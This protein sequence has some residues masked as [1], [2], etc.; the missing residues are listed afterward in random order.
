[1]ETRPPVDLQ[2]VSLITAFLRERF[3]GYEIHTT[4]DTDRSAQFF[5]LALA[6]ATA[7]R[8]YLAKEFLDDNPT[9]GL[10]ALLDDWQLDARIRAAGARE[11][12]V[13]NRGVSIPRMSD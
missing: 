11:V 9:P 5:H 7:H 10:G 3:P 8:V 4:Y 1:M 2:K 13:T 12:L 6:G